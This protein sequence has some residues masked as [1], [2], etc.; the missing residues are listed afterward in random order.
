[1]TSIEVRPGSQGARILHAL[2]AHRWRS[3]QAIL[4]EAGAC[5]LSA[6][7][8]ELRKKGYPIQHVRTGSGRAGHHYRLAQPHP[9]LPERVAPPDAF[10]V[11]GEAFAPRDMAQRY[12]LYAREGNFGDLVLKATGKDSG[13]IGQALFT[14]AEGGD[15]ENCVIGILDTHGDET[16][17][18]DWLVKPW[19]A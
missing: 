14:L 17:K 8:S 16:A 12:R 1:M 7:I 5:S 9:P 2:R 18:G 6:R 13:E 3:G 19:V 15:L 11:P 10:I 4:R